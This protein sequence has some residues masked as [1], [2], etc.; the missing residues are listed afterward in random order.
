MAFDVYVGP[1]CRYRSGDWKNVAQQAA[2]QHGINYQLVRPAEG[3]LAKLSTPKTVPTQQWRNSIREQLDASGLQD[4][5]WDDSP[6]QEYV[7]DRPGWEGHVGFIAQFTYALHP[8]LSPP[9]RALTMQ[10]LAEDPAFEIELNLE[11][12]LAVAILE[13]QMF[14]PGTY[15]RAVTVPGFAGEQICVSSLRLLDL[16]LNT[17]CALCAFDRV[18]LAQEPVDQPS[19]EATFEEAARYGTA[20]YARLVGAALSRNLPLILD[21]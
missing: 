17:I 21:Y 2:E 1:V 11:S 10:E 4:V 3:L 15:M 12:S 18:A 13:C 14:L 19:S 7:T 5:A 16:A 20:I 6:E 8:A 9:A